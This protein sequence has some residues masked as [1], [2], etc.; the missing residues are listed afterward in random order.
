VVAAWCGLG[1]VSTSQA[2]VAPIHAPVFVGTQRLFDVG[3][4]PDQSAADRAVAINR[5]IDS[6]VRNPERIAPVEA[7]L[8]GRERILAIGG[9]DL[10]TATPQDADDNLTTV[11]VLAESWKEELDNALG[12]LREEQQTPW[13]QVSFSIIHSTQSLIRQTAA[14]IPRLVSTMLV[15]VIVFFGSRGARAA[16]RR[17]LERTSI[18][19]NTR[20]LVQTL[21]YYGVWIVG[22]I[23]ALG[24][25]GINPATL[26]AGLGVTTIA[27]GFALKDLLSNFVSGFLILTTRPFALGDQIAVQQYEGTV[28][29]IE[30]RATHLRT[31][32]N[33]LVIIPNAE[34]YTATITNNT[35]SPYCRQAFVV[36]IGY[37]ADLNKAFELAKQ[38]ARE[39][40]GVLVDPAPDVL[41]DDL[42]SG[43]LNLKV[44]FHTDSRRGQAT[45]VGSEARRRVKDAFQQAG[46]EIYPTGPQV[47]QLAGGVPSGSGPAD[48]D[49]QKSP[50]G[51]QP[52]PAEA[53]R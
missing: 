12:P 10:L 50:S 4:L 46:I 28:E 51:R 52:A 49:G 8:R 2:A 39:T 29:R 18:D 17:V 19:A 33:R 20:Q 23:V 13:N 32:D 47:V 30:L 37:E 53:D 25:L 43:S 31:Y 45:T 27:I 21:V 24:T 1:G 48:A 42:A 3:A 36:G 41:V 11:P 34:L 14:L 38:A 26:V 5:R 22:W 16:V 9:R 44:R 40:P 35:A 6:F 7:K 15:V